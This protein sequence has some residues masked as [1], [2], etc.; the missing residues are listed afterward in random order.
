MWLSVLVACSGN[1]G[2]LE[3]DIVINEQQD[4]RVGL[5]AILC[6]EKVGDIRIKISNGIFFFL[7]L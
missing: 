4:R 2:G 1:S 6:A 7:F 3:L 5:S